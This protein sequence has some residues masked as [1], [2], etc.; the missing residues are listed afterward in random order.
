MTRSSMNARSPL[1]GI[2]KAGRSGST[3]GAAGVVVRDLRGFSAVSILAHKGQAAAT[4]ARLSRCLEATVLDAPKRVAHGSLSVSGVAPG[5]WFV[6]ERVSSRSM[7]SDL[8]AGFVGLAVVVDQTD[9]CIVL[10]LAGDCVR[11]TLAKGIPVDLDATVFK[12]GDV[13]H[14]MASHIGVHVALMTEKTGFEV[15]TAASTAGSFCSWLTASAA[16]YG[17]DFE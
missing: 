17:M 2:A 6:I 4:A 13:A 5:Q 11:A 9:S 12:P 15:V 1:A 3:S 7:L 8:C 14:T 10:E 16:E